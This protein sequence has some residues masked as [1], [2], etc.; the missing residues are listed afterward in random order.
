LEAHERKKILVG[1]QPIKKGEVT[2]ENA[3]KPMTWRVD[4][5][6]LWSPQLI[7]V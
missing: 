7:D 3:V 2:R 1:L 5:A 4:F 6:E